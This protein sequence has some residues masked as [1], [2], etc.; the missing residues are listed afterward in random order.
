[1]VLGVP[2]FKLAPL[3]FK[4]ITKP[5]VDTLKKNV[6]RSP[7]WKNSVFVPMARSKDQ[8]LGVLN[9]DLLCKCWEF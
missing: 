4:V 3:A 8:I 9:L 2:L 7:F 1:M 5:F 6:R